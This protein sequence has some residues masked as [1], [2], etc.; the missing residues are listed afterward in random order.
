MS[1]IAPT[2]MR[3]FKMECLGIWFNSQLRW[4]DDF[5]YTRAKS[6]SLRNN[7]IVARAKTLVWFCY[8]RPLLEYAYNIVI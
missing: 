2:A 7:R 6:A 5:D 1:H 4:D 8:E 3:K